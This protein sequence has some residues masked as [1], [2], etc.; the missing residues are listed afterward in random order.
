MGTSD[1]KV[2]L[3]VGHA[4]YE[5]WTSI[6]RD[7]QLE[8]WASDDQLQIMHCHAK[9]VSRLLR[10]IDS[11]FWNLKWNKRF[12][13]IAIAIEILIKAP[14]G[15]F[16][17]NLKETKLFDTS[18]NAL[19]LNIPD[20]DFLMNYKS[21]A[22]TTGI[23]KFDFDFVVITTSSSY[24]SLN[25]LSKE[26][27][28]LPRKNT[29]AGR[30]LEQNGIQFA[31]GSFKVFSRDIVE[32]IRENKKL[33]SKWRAD[34]LAY[35]FQLKKINPSVNYIKL[36]SIDADSESIIESLTDLDINSI[37]H[38]RLK[39]GTQKKRNDVFL[40]NLLHKRLIK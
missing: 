9:P 14:F 27:S 5:P 12:G 22:V 1:A 32:S 6:L 39:S 17:G 8:T 23:L 4:L 11:K 18:H 31:S 34:D 40:M 3:L 35:G 7:G 28:K 2:L 20:L 24:L 29:V 36:R 10:K 25:L 37:V 26:I 16:V 30:I 15:L 33:Y 19:L 21:F 38:Y 13:K